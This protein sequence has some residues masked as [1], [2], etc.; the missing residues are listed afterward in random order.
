MFGIFDDIIDAGVNVTKKVVNTSVDVATLGN[1]DTINKVVNRGIDL[2]SEPARD[3]V[4]I[5]EGL[6][7]GEL[8]AKATVRLGADVIVGLGSAEIIDLLTQ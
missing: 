7:E 5:L 4:E 3:S 6:S 1:G 2:V 8:R